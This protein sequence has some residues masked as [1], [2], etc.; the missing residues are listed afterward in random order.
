M[1]WTRKFILAFAKCV[2]K[3]WEFSFDLLGHHVTAHFRMP[4]SILAHSQYLSSLFSWSWRDIAA[5][6]SA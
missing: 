4:R 5:R 3:A 2:L 6:S 1:E